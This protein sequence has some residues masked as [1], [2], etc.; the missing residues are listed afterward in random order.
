M[1]ED[2]GGNGS[3]WLDSKF[4]EKMS[5]DGTAL[6][7]RVLKI[8]KSNTRKNVKYIQFHQ[9]YAHNKDFKTE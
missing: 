5:F 3:W 6:D 4:W 9:K 2:R 7:L 1:A 8:K